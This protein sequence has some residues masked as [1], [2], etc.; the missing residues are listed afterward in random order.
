MIHQIVKTLD[1]K[2]RIPSVSAHCDIPCKIYDP[3]AAQISTL[4]IIRMT[5]LIIEAEN[6]GD[7]KNSGYFSTLQRLI[8]I[9]EEHGRQLKEEIRIIWGDYFK[10]PQLDAFPEIHE[11]THEIMLLTSKVKQST[12]K[13]ATLSLLEKV[14]HFAEIFWTTKNVETYRAVCP[15][16][17]AQEV[18]Y[19]KLN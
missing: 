3:A 6:I 17:P 7:E 9:K 12:D 18:V 4:T 16:P 2:Q 10:Q 15:Y 19:P 14:N 5:D 13:N 8:L 11:L 1:K